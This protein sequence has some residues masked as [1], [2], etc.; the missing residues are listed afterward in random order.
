MSSKT[1]LLALL[2]CCV[3]SMVW[4]QSPFDGT[5]KLNT[6][7]SN[8]AGDTMTIE[9]AGNGMLKYTDSDESFSFKTDG[10]PVKT[11]LGQDRAYTKN[12]D[13]SYT[14]TVKVRGTLV[15]T[16]TWKVAADG[17]T[18]T[19]ESKGT[20]PNG[21]TFDDFTTLTR[22]AP[23]SGILG[24]WKSTEVKLSSPN[25]LGIK[26]DGDDVTLTISAIK[27]TCQAKWDGKDHA[28]SGPTV[29]DGLTVAL[30][31]TG[32]TTYKMVRKLKDKTLDI[33]RYRVAKDGQA[34][35]AK[36]TDGEGKEPFTEV[37][38]KQG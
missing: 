36:G 27:A 18:I 35:Y 38:D 13:G 22:I 30:T 9:D 3:S 10:T 2:A 32:P 29:P 4:A 17:N 31:K 14:S 21:D 15:R 7:K 6:A 16:N 5:W 25:T 11:P 19:I 23:G 26:T 28:C 1:P 24:G 12:A 33:I 8:L 34:L 37:F 20:K